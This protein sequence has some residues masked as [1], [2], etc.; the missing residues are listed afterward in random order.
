MQYKKLELIRLFKCFGSHQMP[1]KLT[2][3]RSVI[4]SF[5]YC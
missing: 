5:L 3:N 1:Y 2:D 4:P